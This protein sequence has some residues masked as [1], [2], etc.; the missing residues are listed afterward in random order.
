[1][2]QRAEGGRRR[3]VAGKHTGRAAYDGAAPEGD[4]FPVRLR[5]PLSSR[6]GSAAC[7]RGAAPRAAAQEVA[8]RRK[9]ISP[10]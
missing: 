3:T 6:A 4:Y 2:R 7:L 5:G 1:M 10:V 9:F 8:R